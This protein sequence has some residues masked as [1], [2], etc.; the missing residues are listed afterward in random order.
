[1]GKSD[2]HTPGRNTE[3]ASIHANAKQHSVA[4]CYP[5]SG[6]STEKKLLS[7]LRA[8]RWSNDGKFVVG[9]Y[10]G[11]GKGRVGDVYICPAGSQPCEKLTIGYNP[12]WSRDDSVIYYLRPG[13]FPQVAE[14]W[15]FNRKDRREVH[16]ADLGRCTPSVIFSTYRLRARS[17]TPNSNLARTNYGS[18]TFPPIE[19]D[20]VESLQKVLCR[21][22][23]FRVDGRPSEKDSY[24]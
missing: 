24:F 5:R 16:L 11:S 20:L 8:P 22:Q 13:Q 23:P 12:I 7:P 10:V 17:P 6:V 4:H 21:R 9:G 2:G 14:L 15:S 19:F 1:M 18:Q 3:V